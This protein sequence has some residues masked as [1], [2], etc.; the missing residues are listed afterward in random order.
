MNLNL[1]PKYSFR[2][3]DP[4]QPIYVKLSLNQLKVSHGIVQMTYKSF[5]EQSTITQT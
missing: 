5:T 3:S 2:V 4:I 1:N